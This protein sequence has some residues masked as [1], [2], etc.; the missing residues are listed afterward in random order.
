[1]AKK[2]ILLEI[3]L[4]DSEFED[5][6]REVEDVK[7]KTKQFEFNEMIKDPT[8]RAALISNGW[9][10]TSNLEKTWEPGDVGPNV[11]IIRGTTDYKSAYSVDISTNQSRIGSN[12]YSYD[13]KK[14]DRLA[15]EVTLDGLTKLGS[16]VPEQ[17][18][19]HLIAEKKAKKTAE[20]KK[21]AAA[22][23]RKE[24]AEKKAAQAM[25]KMKQELLKSGYKVVPAES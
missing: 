10:D 21:R 17:I 1:M 12:W 13:P 3:E 18:R 20:E 4:Q 6:Y 22:I 9:V 8:F 5:D 7:V 14:G 2:Y 24:K 23:A 15:V 11:Y 25:E 16:E 19:K